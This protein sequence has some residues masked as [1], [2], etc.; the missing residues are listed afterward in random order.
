T[1]ARL[2]NVEAKSA[3][4]PLA[5]RTLGRLAVTTVVVGT[6]LFLATPMGFGALGGLVLYQAVFLSSMLSAVLG[7]G[8]H[9]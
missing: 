3:R 5:M 2:K 1:V 4:R 6:L 9:S 8:V 7:S